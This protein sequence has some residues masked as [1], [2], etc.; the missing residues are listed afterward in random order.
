M[1][2]Q[3]QSERYIFTNGWTMKR[4]TGTLWHLRDSEGSLVDRDRY[5]HDIIPRHNLVVAEHRETPQ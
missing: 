1:G 3:E 2:K 4:E 5:R